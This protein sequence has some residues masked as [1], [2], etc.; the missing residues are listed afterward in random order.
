MTY[1]PYAVTKANIVIPPEAPAL[2]ERDGNAGEVDTLTTELDSAAAK[3]ESFSSFTDS[4]STLDG[5]EGGAAAEYGDA[6]SMA[7]T[8]AA[9]AA[10][11]LRAGASAARAYSATLTT[12][13]E[14]HD[15]IAEDRQAYNSSRGDLSDA[16]DAVS[17]T[18]TTAILALVDR[19]KTISDSYFDLSS[20][21]ET[22]KTDA[23]AADDTFTSAL[24][25]QDSVA[26]VNEIA[27]AGA[28]G[29]PGAP[30]PNTTGDPADNAA[31]WNSL[32][33]AQRAAMLAIHPEIVGNLD[34]LP[35]DVRDN[36]NRSA[37]DN[38]ITSLEVREGSWPGLLPHEQEAL[39]N[40]R[41]TRDAL[42]DPSH[43][44]PITGERIP[45]YLY[46]FKPDAHLSD[47]G[48]AISLGNPDDAENLAI[49]V[50]G[51]MNSMQ[52]VGDGVNSAYNLY[53]ASSTASPGSRTAVMFWLDYNSPDWDGGNVDLDVVGA[54]SPDA[55]I[56]GSRNLT[57]LV[58]GIRTQNTSQNLNLTAV[59][60]S[61]GSMVVSQAGARSDEPLFDQY[62]L[63]GSPGPGPGIT[64]AA[65]LNPG[66]PGAVYVGVA[67]QDPVPDA[68]DAHGADTATAAF[69]GIRFEAEDVDRDDHHGFDD[70]NQ[71]FNATYQGATG[72]SYSES[73]QNMGLIVGGQSSEVSV[74]EH[75]GTEVVPHPYLNGVQGLVEVDPESSRTPEESAWVLGD[76]GW[77]PSP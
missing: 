35:A 25:A 61:Y 39:D 74:A 7:G 27:V 17:D 72:V 50:P 18:D 43:V 57:S 13:K 37:M 58:E 71:Y 70:H 55:A 53:H 56:A 59:G 12:L 15:N 11:G 23:K 68:L 75:E 41:A 40:A 77:M 32:T 14:R 63:I 76:Q 67:S 36:A 26:E 29:M 48:V 34:G 6:V 46:V 16:K 5:W 1:T 31:W 44:D 33:P 10:A 28:L 42:D 21:I 73:L 49:S 9:P 19:A 8:D 38:L 4:A 65:D 22:W 69:G 30:Q 64:T 20:T 60:H 66:I 51:M 24:A 3:L 54:A 2:P 45:S 62:V 47:G 52:A